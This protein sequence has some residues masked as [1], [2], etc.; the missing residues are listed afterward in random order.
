VQHYVGKHSSI[1]S[2][3]IIGKVLL[4]NGTFVIFLIFF[5]IQN[6][7]YNLIILSLKAIIATVA[8][9]INISSTIF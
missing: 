3:L 7:K 5:L 8:T 9:S 6:I 2:A 1:Y 4:E